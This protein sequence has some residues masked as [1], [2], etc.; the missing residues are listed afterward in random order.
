MSIVVVGTG[1]VGLVTGTC[2]ADLGHHVCCVDIDQEKIN[3]LKQGKVPFFEPGLSDK[4]KRNT[5]V[6][7]LRFSTNL[8]NELKDAKFIFNAVGTPSK[9][10]GE[11][12]LS[13]VFNVVDEILNWLNKN[14]DDKHR[15]LI[16]KSTVPVLTGNRIKEK[17][18]SAGCKH[19]LAV[20]SNPEFLREGNAVYDF[21]HP[22][23]IVL[24]SDNQE[25]MDQV[26]K[27]YE[28]LYR[29]ENPI[30]KTDLQTAELSKY[31]SNAFLATKISFIN[32][33]A[34]LCEKFDANIKHVS[35]IMGKDGRIGRYF[36]HAGPGYGGSCFPKD[37]QALIHFSKE[38]GYDFKLGKATQE[39]NL[40][41][42]QH[43][44]TKL[45]EFFPEGVKGKKVGLLGLAFK[46][47]TDDM[48]DSPAL[49]VIN[50]LLLEDVH[51]QAF[52]PES[53][54]NA[55][56]IYGNKIT[57]CKNSYETADGVDAI[58]IL[59]EWNMFR[60][61]NLDKLKSLMKGSIFMDF[62]GIYN[63]ENIENI[64]D[65]VHIVGLKS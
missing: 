3:L 10:S 42:K 19:R 15:V 56:K 39:V 65:H 14:E 30:I 2:L 48:R 5:E 13:Y 25:F 9:E 54:E 24:G 52:D 35:K 45:K 20:V 1:Y 32:E 21:F 22:D 63:L 55:K 28:S 47:N 26:A 37:V 41:Q 38:V 8:A 50:E 6:E 62:R 40:L 33:M 46:P 61:L 29:T 43:V 58:I 34:N 64:F 60:E 12:N 27:L 16:T 31:A 57:Y 18:E 36:L 53:M 7:Q 17:I 51:I 44:V 59:T 4:I 11:A 49:T 23:R